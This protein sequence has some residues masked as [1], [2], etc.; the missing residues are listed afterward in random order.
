MA[1][2]P[3]ML[4]FLAVGNAEVGPQTEDERADGNGKGEGEQNETE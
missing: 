4:G 3:A 1:A 2:T